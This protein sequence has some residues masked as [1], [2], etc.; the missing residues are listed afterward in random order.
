ME[1]TLRYVAPCQ[2][3]L[4]GILAGELH[5]MDAQDV[6]AENGRVLFSGGLPAGAVR[7]PISAIFSH[8]S[9]IFVETPSEREAACRKNLF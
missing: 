5:R 1:T 8:P 6:L 7:N 3:G 9:V 2:F 4:E